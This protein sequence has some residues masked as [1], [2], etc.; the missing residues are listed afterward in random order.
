MEGL[1]AGLRSQTCLTSAI[2][3]VPLDNNC[4]GF[5]I[6]P[7]S[8]LV[9]QLKGWVVEA[10]DTEGSGSKAKP[11]A[12]PTPYPCKAVLLCCCVRNR[13]ST[14]PDVHNRKWNSIPEPREPYGACVP[15][16]KKYQ[17]TRL[18]V[19]VDISFNTWTFLCGTLERSQ[20]CGHRLH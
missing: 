20:I 4:R 6:L 5:K 2:S 1:T 16:L 7:A 14:P 19:Y 10:A 9:H 15:T 13:I 17:Q 11:I 3:R 12:K 8:F 18:R